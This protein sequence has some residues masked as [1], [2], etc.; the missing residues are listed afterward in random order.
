MISPPQPYN[1]I[2]SNSTLDPNTG[3]IISTANTITTTAHC[4][5]ASTILNSS[6][7]ITMTSP[8]GIHV[9]SRP[10]GDGTSYQ[11]PRPFI[12]G[13]IGHVPPQP[14]AP[15]TSI[16]KVCWEISKSDKLIVLFLEWGKLLL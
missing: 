16:I 15:T 5:T 2:Q 11:A 4:Q 7:T 12:P 10:W 6:T 1:A 8:G 13:T 9:A 14:T 3:E